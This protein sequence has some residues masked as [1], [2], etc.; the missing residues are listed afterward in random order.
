MQLQLQQIAR[1][2]KIILTVGVLLFLVCTALFAFT[3]NFIFLGA[4]FALPFIGWFCLD[5]KSFYWF[6]IF[7]IPLF[8]EIYLGNLST[9]VPDEQMMWMFV[10]LVFIVLAANYRR[11]PGWF[12]KHPL[13]LILF[14]QF[15]WLIVAV[16]FSQNHILSL[17]FLAAKSWF[18]ISY[19]VL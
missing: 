2:G 12:L 13:T 17:K 14:L 19:T 5:W 6:F 10:P 11:L 16:I 18:L 3:G 9:T 1:H 8:C 4:P 7:T 15:T